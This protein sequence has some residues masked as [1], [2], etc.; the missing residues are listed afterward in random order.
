MFIV[1]SFHSIRY[2]PASYKY[3][4]TLAIPFIFA[5]LCTF[6]FFKPLLGQENSALNNPVSIPGTPYNITPPPNWLVKTNPAVNNVK[7]T[8][9]DALM[10]LLI[11]ASPLE[12]A[13]L[14]PKQLVD[15]TVAELVANLPAGGNWQCIEN[16]LVD[17]PTELMRMQVYEGTINKKIY[18]LA[19]IA[20]AEKEF[21][22]SLYALMIP[23]LHDTTWPMI[24]K[25]GCQYIEK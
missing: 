18:H 13:E 2:Q 10:W 23:A 19:L 1:K 7:L 24:Q 11:N 15:D 21:I 17:Q 14:S 25:N 16:R 22:F 12:I 3:H 6:I 9:P 8:S 20:R 5:L 4:T